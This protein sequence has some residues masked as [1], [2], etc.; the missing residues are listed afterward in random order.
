MMVSNKEPIRFIPCT[1]CTKILHAMGVI[2]SLDGTNRKLR[3]YLISVGPE[4]SKVLPNLFVIKKTIMFNVRLKKV[5]DM[6]D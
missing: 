3:G 5:H 4:T 1:V 6:F 2:F